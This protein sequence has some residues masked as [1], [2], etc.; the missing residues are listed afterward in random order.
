V[1]QPD[2]MLLALDELELAL[3]DSMASSEMMLCRARLVVERLRQNLPF[4]QTETGE[5]GPLLALMN[6]EPTRTLSCAVRRLRRAIAVVL[7]SEGMT[8][9][10][11]AERLGV[12]RQ[13]VSILIKDMHEEPSATHVDLERPVT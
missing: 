3:K 8:M 10:H 2:E 13:R 11:V 7:R 12:S 9:D 5:P 6:R 1:T 4:D